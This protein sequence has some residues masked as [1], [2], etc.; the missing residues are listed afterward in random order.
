MLVLTKIKQTFGAM[1]Q[2][3]EAIKQ[4]FGAEDMEDKI[5]LNI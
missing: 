1:K 2:T 5:M 3:F 4:T